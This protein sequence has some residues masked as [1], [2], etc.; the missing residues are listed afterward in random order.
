[1][2]RFLA[3]LLL[4]LL[5]S[6]SPDLHTNNSAQYLNK[7]VVFG[8]THGTKDIPEFFF[9]Q[10][11]AEF[12]H[13]KNVTVGLELPGRFNNLF[14]YFNS[15][16]KPPSKSTIRKKITEDNFWCNL[17]DG[18]DSDAMLALLVNLIHLKYNNP[19]GNI[20]ILSLKTGKGFYEDGAPYY[21]EI[22]RSNNNTSGFILIGNHHARLAEG[23][24]SFASELKKQNLEVITLNAATK[25]GSFTQCLIGGTCETKPLKGTDR[26][27]SEGVFL[28]EN[29]NN[30]YWFDGDYFI[31]TITPAQTAKNL[32]N[33]CRDTEYN[34]MPFE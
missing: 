21:A 12:N 18:R 14:K 29:T 3:I 30:N 8:E 25:N 31:K 7:V 20:S 9:E 4:S 16:K 24:K 34:S 23:Q 19:T 11:T 22:F 32:T 15:L 6:C 28:L 33:E 13:T 5:F 17:T 1:M 26:Y 2:K 27:N 10:I